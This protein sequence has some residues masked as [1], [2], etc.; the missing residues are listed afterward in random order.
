MPL[1]KAVEWHHADFCS[2]A[3]FRW[4]TKKY[5]MG[6]KESTHKEIIYTSKILIGNNCEDVTDLLADVYNWQDN[7]NTNLW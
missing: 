4:T 3:L 6:K 7:I 1:L 2:L 5:E